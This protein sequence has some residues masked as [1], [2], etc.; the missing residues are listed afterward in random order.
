MESAQMLIESKIQNNTHKW[1]EWVSTRAQV[2]GP[3]AA[4]TNCDNIEKDT[5]IVVITGSYNKSC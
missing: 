1:Q 5:I 2:T 3:E 4:S